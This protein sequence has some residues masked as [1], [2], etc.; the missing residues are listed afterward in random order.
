MLSVIVKTVVI[1]LLV[2][3]VVHLVILKTLDVSPPPP[4]P[5]YV[6]TIDHM[7]DEVVKKKD[8]TPIVQ[9]STGIAPPKNDD[10]F[11]Y[12][13]NDAKPSLS[14]AVST[15]QPAHTES[16]ESTATINGLCDFED[17]ALSLYCDY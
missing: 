1:F 8:D 2:I 13:Y 17:G 5:K 10:L 14:V 16:T 4:Q 7:I 3:I 6:E 15:A 9:S 11:N 12:V